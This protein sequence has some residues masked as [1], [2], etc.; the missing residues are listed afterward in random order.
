M[1]FKKTQERSCCYCLHATEA[2][3]ETV[4]CAKHGVVNSDHCCWKFSYDPCKRIPKKA[5]APDF[6]QYNADD[7]SL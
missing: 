2:G 7:F 3:N 1:L 6:T 5:K 4:Q